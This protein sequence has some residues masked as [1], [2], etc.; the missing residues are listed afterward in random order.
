[1]FQLED[2]LQ[3]ERD[4]SDDLSRALQEHADR[5]SQLDRE[6]Q[7]AQENV[8]RLEEKLRQRDEEE[9]DYSQ[10][11]KQREAEAEE[12]REE[13]SNLRR[14][15]TRTA[16]ELKRALEE[17]SSQENGARAQVENLVRQQATF[18]IDLKTSADKI[19]ALKEEVERQRR[20][21]Q[22]LQQESADKEVKLVQLNKQHQ[23][24]KEDLEGMNTALDSKQMELELVS[25]YLFF[26]S[27]YSKP[28]FSS[29]ATSAFVVQ[30]VQLPHLPHE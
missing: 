15:Y 13:I 27:L 28:W 7:F 24:D 16:D 12:L 9:K 6:R 3:S 8:S 20:R 29:S 21:I 30:P 17:T 19:N 10:Q 2:Q 14:E 22:V 25:R 26:V 4:H 1:M 23:R 11:I 18:D 5:I